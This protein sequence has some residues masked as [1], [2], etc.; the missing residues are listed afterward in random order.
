MDR[1]EFIL[2][3]CA[4]CVGATALGG[5][6]SSCGSSK[7]VTGKLNNDGLLLDKNEFKLKE[8]GKYRSYIIVRN[9][10][11]VFPVCVYRFSETEYSALWMQCTHQGAELNVAGD[12]LQCPAHGSEFDNRGRM[13][14]GPADTDL[15]VFPVTVTHNQ[16]FIDLRKK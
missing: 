14:G 16:I 6:F 8:E 10:A 15:R 7:L 12:H 1:K 11:L 13:I 2:K 9:E 5:L 4:A 3:T